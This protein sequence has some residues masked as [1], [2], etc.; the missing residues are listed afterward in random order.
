MTVAP[1][2]LPD[3]TPIAADAVAGRPAYRLLQMNL[4]YD[5]AEPAEAIPIALAT[6][7]AK[8]SNHRAVTGTPRSSAART[9]CSA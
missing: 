8:T 5:V 9:T 3:S 4:R 7:I 2:V 1:Y 6:N